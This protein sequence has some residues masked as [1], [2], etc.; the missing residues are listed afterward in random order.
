MRNLEEKKIKIPTLCEIIEAVDE[1]SNDVNM[2]EYECIGNYTNSEN[3]TNYILVNIEEGN[4]EGILN[5]SNLNDL[6]SSIE[7]GNLIEKI[8]PEFSLENLMKIVFFEMDN[9]NETIRANDFKFNFVIKGK[10]NKDL[11]KGFYIHT[12]FNLSEIDNKA[13]C[14]FEVGENKTANLSCDLN[15]E[16]HK[17]IRTFSFK[18]SQIQ[19]TEGDEINFVKLNDLILI[20]SVE[21]KDK[22]KKKLII[23]VVICSVVGVIGIGLAI[24][25]IVRCLKSKKDNIETKNNDKGKEEVKRYEVK[26]NDK[27]KNI[28]LKP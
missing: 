13:N 11:G 25:F 23:I 10:L 19:T 1:T 16:N 26:D 18:T 24:F 12:K 6:A 20:N 3:L 9:N 28:I 2:I 27:S 4:N 15:V 8:D 5:T 14:L 7:L 17:D 21:K 22:S